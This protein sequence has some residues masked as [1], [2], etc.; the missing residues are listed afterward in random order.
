MQSNLSDPSLHPLWQN[1]WPNM[2]P[3]YWQQLSVMIGAGLAVDQSLR[4]LQGKQSKDLK[5]DKTNT[6]VNK[7]IDS[8]LPRIIALVER[9]VSLADAFKR[10]SAISEFDYRL[11]KS[12]ETAG[13]LEQGLQHIAVRWTK[14]LQRVNSLKSSLLMPVVVLII[15]ALA[16]VFVRVLLSNQ[17]VFDASVSIAVIV[18]YVLLFFSLMLRALMLDA[19]IYLSFLWPIAFVRRR[20]LRY[21]RVFE[22]LFYRSLLWQIES[23][24][25]AEKATSQ[26]SDVL[27]VKSFKVSVQSAAT[28]M[29]A[30]QSLPQ[31]LVDHNLVLT[32]RMQ[33]VLSIANESGRYEQAVA[34][35]LVIQRQKLDLQ[36]NDDFKWLARASYVLVL[37]VISRLVFI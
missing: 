37:V 1:M 11:L 26:C 27:S 2:W 7:K 24:V 16:G 29:G 15:G 21:Q 23:G 18:F 3:N 14:H 8:Q 9:G 32:K 25:A 33:Q 34:R 20:S 13:R 4:T 10:T 17:T 6:A 35:E 5:P 28:Q 31:C 36:L 30:G 22:Q 12:A 19:R